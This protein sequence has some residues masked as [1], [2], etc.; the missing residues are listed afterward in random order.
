MEGEDSDNRCDDSTHHLRE[1]STALARIRT[2]AMGGVYLAQDRLVSGGRI[3]ATLTG[4]KTACRQSKPS[5]VTIERCRR[6]DGFAGG[7]AGPCDTLGW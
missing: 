7:G 4:V 3:D 5:T 6:G 2:C 1:R